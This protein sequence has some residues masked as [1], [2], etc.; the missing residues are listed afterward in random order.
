MIDLL[1]AVPDDVQLEEMAWRLA[2][3]TRRLTQGRAV[4]AWR[5]QVMA[6]WVPLQILWA[7]RE[8]NRRGNPGALFGFRVLAGT[9]AGK[10]IERWLSRKQCYIVARQMGFTYPRGDNDGLPY[11]APEEFVR[12]RLLGLVLPEL[13]R[14]GPQFQDIQVSPTLLAWNKEILK[15]RA[16]VHP[17]FRCQKDLPASFP[18]WKCP[19]GF[20]QCAAGTHRLNWKVQEC[21]KC[22]KRAMV[23]PERTDGACV[24]CCWNA[25][26]GESR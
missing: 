3:N 25:S 15:R 7:R 5:V 24:D 12:L 19:I 17:K 1:G 23:D 4:P 14:D 13:C 26:R 21:S 9:P 8:P 2:G 6:E 16:R 11:A 10:L 18:C 20:L 22:K